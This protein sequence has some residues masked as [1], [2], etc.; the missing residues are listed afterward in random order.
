MKRLV[1]ALAFTAAFLIAI[2]QGVASPLSTGP[3]GNPLWKIPLETLSTTRERPLFS[4]SRR[5]PPPEI[6][7]ALS[8]TS[9]HARKRLSEPVQPPLTL[10]GTIAGE[11]EGF[12]IFIDP[13]TKAVIRLK[14]GSDYHGW[15]L[16]SVKGREVTVEKNHLTTLLSLP[17]HANGQTGTMRQ[18]AM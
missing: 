15:V 9:L 1:S 14:I 2:A 5:P 11:T 17:A 8:L 6:T 16:R 12:G 13:S 10:I 18:E 3:T 7:R 4:P